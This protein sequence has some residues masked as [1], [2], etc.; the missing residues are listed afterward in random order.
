MD[1]DN[2]G[3]K[4][5][6]K[7]CSAK[8]YDLN[9]KPIICPKCGTDNT[10]SKKDQVVKEKIF[11]DDVKK[12]IDVENILSEELNED[13]SFEDDVDADKDENIINIE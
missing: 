6:C 11:K 8:F 9:K 5:I 12:D 4:H 7:N 2:K 13:I 3:N 10:N 1:N